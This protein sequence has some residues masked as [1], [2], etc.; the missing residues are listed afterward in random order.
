MRFCFK[1][2]LSLVLS[3]KLVDSLSRPPRARPI[4]EPQAAAAASNLRGF[5]HVD[6]AFQAQ[7]G[8]QLAFWNRR[9]LC[10]N[11]ITSIKSGGWF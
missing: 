2:C 7:P 5:H 4:A 1:R 11:E 10:L 8:L 6:V 9:M 3:S